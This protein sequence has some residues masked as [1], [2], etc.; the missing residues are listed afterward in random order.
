M[1]SEP[2]VGEVIYCPLKARVANVGS[3][4][5]E[6]LDGRRRLL[7][8]AAGQ[9]EVSRISAD[10]GEAAG[11]TSISHLTRRRTPTDT[12][13]ALAVSGMNDVLNSQ[14]YT[15]QLGGTVRRF[16]PGA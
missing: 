9:R 13:R 3:L 14:G 12:V 15:Q 5:R 10:Y 1:R 6:Y 4:L 2:S 11:R 8:T 7:R 16:P